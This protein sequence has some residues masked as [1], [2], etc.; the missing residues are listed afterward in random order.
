MFVEGLFVSFLQLYKK[1]FDDI[2]FLPS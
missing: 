1:D 2:T